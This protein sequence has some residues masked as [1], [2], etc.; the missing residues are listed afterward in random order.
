VNN[1]K[2]SNLEN[3]L[4]SVDALA[5][6]AGISRQ[7]AF[8]AWYACHFFS[9][10]EDD[11]LE[12]AGMDGG[13]DQGIDLVYADAN[14][15]QIY[16]IQ[17]H[18]PENTKK[19]TPKNKWDALTACVPV[20]ENP[21]IIK[22]QG[23]TELY[24]HISSIKT[25]YSE[26]TVIFGLISLGEKSDAIDKN[27]SNIKNSP[28]LG[29]YEF[30]YDS[31][32]DIVNK[33][34]AL[35]SA[36]KSVPEDSIDF[37][38][39]F[40]G[41][42]GKYGQAWF[43][44]V[45]AKELIRL[46]NKYR[47]EIFSGNVRMF[48]GARKGS[49]NEHI[50][51]TAKESPGLFWALN[52]GIS[53]VANSVNMVAENKNKLILRRFSIVNGCQTTSCLAE[54]NAN[55][56]S[57]LVRII[58]AAPAVVSDIVQFNNSQNAVKIWAVRSVDD[59]QERLRVEFDGIGISYAPKQEGKKKRKDDI[60]II[61]LDKL[62]QFLA[63][64]HGEYLI[65]AINNKTELFDQPYQNIF[66]H[67]I[68]TSKVYFYWRVGVLAD[69]ARI[70]RLQDLKSENDR[71]SN[72][73]LGVSGTYWIIYCCSRLIGNLNKT[74]ESILDV[75]RQ[76]SKEFEGA[77]LKYVEAALDIYFDAASDTYDEN[78]YGSVRSALRSPRF[79]Q[80]FERKLSNKLASRAKL[81]RLPQLSAAIKSASI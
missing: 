19:K 62:T 71:I 1:S 45:S 35:L 72:S 54:A 50:V 20:Y 9:A 65:Q 81:L 34:N 10:D 68:K 58:E 5:G 12:L 8:A 79:F 25:Q 22:T 3:L 26:Y 21:E 47:S 53:I 33:Y 16:I 60:K 51:K 44:T 40:I 27:S 80:N 31:G 24:E 32:D 13:E 23:R 64:T 75:E 14:T 59:I 61:E 67:N 7:R 38:N 63:S 2:P 17:S 43:G 57:V 74:F 78:E 6:R 77:L 46:R 37:E 66:M 69:A 15:N 70:N 48:M 30:F 29:A 11:V 41:H 55:D 52:N 73:F 39:G 49:I 56:A 76:I 28:T 36:E 4:A 42:K 18:C